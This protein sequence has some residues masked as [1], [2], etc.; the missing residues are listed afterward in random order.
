[1]K[2]IIILSFLLISMLVIVGCVQD[3]QVVTTENEAIEPAMEEEAQDD[4][5]KEE[6]AMQEEPAAPVEEVQAVEPE[7]EERLVVNSGSSHVIEMTGAGFDVGELNVRVGDT[8]EFKN[9]RQ[10]KINGINNAMVI[11][12]FECR[13]IKSGIIKLGESFTYTTDK[14]LNCEIVDGIF[15]DEKMQLIVE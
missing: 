2:K 1:M 5:M 11:G 3:K 14:E 12:T 15:V 7:E 13:G 4:A 8:I 6:P 10:E 9:N